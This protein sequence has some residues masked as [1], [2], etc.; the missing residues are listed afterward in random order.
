MLPMTSLVR[1]DPPNS[2]GDCVRAALASILE[3]PTAAVPHFF[4]DGCDGE[5]AH[6]RIR[7]F[8]RSIGAVPVFMTFPASVELNDILHFM[9]EMNRDVY[10]MLFGNTNTGSHVVVCL[11]DKV[12]HDT[13]WYKTPLTH[14]SDFWQIMIVADGRTAHRG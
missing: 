3:Y 13:N 11:N 7:E 10:Y 4:H 2:Y 8:L 6:K 1:H 14:A 5:E 9:G 12:V